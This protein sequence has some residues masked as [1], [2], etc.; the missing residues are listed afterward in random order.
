[1]TEQSILESISKHEKMK[2]EKRFSRGLVFHSEFL[3]PFFYQE[4]SSNGVEHI[5]NY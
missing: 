3:V 1:M 5:K 2:R 4:F